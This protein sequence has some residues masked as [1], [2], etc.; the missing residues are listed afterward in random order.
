MRTRPDDTRNGAFVRALSCMSV[1]VMSAPHETRS[2]YNCG[3]SPPG[4]SAPTP[5]EAA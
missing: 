2:V 4:P 3:A 5:V 1:A